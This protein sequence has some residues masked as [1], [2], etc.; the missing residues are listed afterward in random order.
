MV[1][2]FFAEF[3]GSEMTSEKTPAV[4]RIWLFGIW[5]KLC[6]LAKRIPN[7]ISND[8]LQIIVSFNNV[9]LG[10]RRLGPLLSV[11]HPCPLQLRREGSAR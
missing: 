8:D 5:A 11:L 3:T 4:P 7:R 10:P 6:K 2:W 1:V 9:P